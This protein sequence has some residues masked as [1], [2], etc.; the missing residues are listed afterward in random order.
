MKPLTANFAEVNDEVARLVREAERA[1][2]TAAKWERVAERLDQQR[3]TYQAENEE[4]AEAIRAAETRAAQARAEVVA[5]LVPQAVEDGEAY[6]AAATDESTASARLAISGR[7]GRRKARQE[8]QAVTEH[9]RRVRE[10]AR[11]AWGGLPRQ[12]D[13]FSEWAVTAAERRAEDDPRVL[14]AARALAAA[15]T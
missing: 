12:A 6:L 5:E 4:N 7:L 11:D 8:H 9:T 13:A 10:R 2:R 3:A 15:Q 1:E 14:D